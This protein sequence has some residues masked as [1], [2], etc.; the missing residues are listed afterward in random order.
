M[1]RIKKIN[2]IGEKHK[3]LTISLFP[4][5]AILVSFIFGSDTVFA[6]YTK[7]IKHPGIL[8]TDYTY[9]G[10]FYGTLLNI[11]LL[12]FLN[13]LIIYF[14]K[15]PLN[16]LV[17]AGFFTGVGFAAFGKTI[18]NVVPIYLGGYLY[19]KKE[20]I[21][22]RNIFGILMFAAGM[23]P[24]ISFILFNGN[25]NFYQRVIGGLGGGIFLGYIMPTL[26]PH[27]LK[28]HE[29]H[30]LYNIGFTLGMFGILLASFMRGKGLELTFYSD[31]SREFDYHFKLILSLT[32]CFYILFG[33]LINNK[34]FDNFDSL[35][36][37]SGRLLSD[38]II[39]EG[40]GITLINAG[41]LGLASI[42]LVNFLEVPINGPLFAGI[43][44][45]FGF[46]ALGK[47]PFNCVPVVIGVL[48]G[49]LIKVGEFNN[50]NIAL[51]A[52]FSTT[53]A[54]ISGVYGPLYGVIAGI[55]HLFVVNNTSFI[56]GGMNLYNNGFSGGLIASI[57]VPIIQKF[58]LGE[59]YE[60]KY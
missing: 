15:I 3:L 27:M 31:I 35:V 45:V 25:L 39:T 22:F 24:L 42:G 29:G 19:S 60:S 12:S 17:F 47:T 49:S 58:N 5:L 36:S 41:I 4:I 52:L 13:I 57:M 6:E 28:I 32:F 26:P 38:F 1:K 11:S 53:L 10:G 9:V 46:G 37:S 23:A 16:G 59:K 30:N 44:T 34:G 43:F 33:Y 56:H 14:F 2:I 21:D 50:F 8:I 54:P 48:F 55:L 51:T 18:V 7:I 40:F 20:K